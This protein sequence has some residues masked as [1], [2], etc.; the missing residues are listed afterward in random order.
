MGCQQQRDAWFTCSLDSQ[1][2]PFP[3]SLSTAAT[4]SAAA[5]VPRTS[6]GTCSWLLSGLGVA[7]HRAPCP[8]WMMTS[9]C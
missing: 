8:T 4:R 9:P 2:P 5:G 6:L 3:H 7:L 1:D